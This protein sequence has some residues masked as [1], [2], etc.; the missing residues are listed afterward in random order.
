MA[1]AGFKGRHRGSRVV[2]LITA[3]RPSHTLATKLRFKALGVVRGW[4]PRRPSAHRAAELEK[5]QRALGAK[6][7]LYQDMAVSGE[8][9][10]HARK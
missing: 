6:A 2:A 10:A 5:A 9:E 7:L 8:T 4:N 1:D 3:T